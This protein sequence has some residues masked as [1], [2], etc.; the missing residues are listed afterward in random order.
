MEDNK[1]IC[2]TSNEPYLYS[3][4]CLVCGEEFSTTVEDPL[5]PKC[6]SDEICEGGW[7]SEEDENE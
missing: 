4:Q 1:P 2:F 7:D 6:G 3:Y 5:C